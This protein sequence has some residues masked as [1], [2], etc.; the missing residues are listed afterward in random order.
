VNDGIG[1]YTYDLRN[2]LLEQSA[3][4]AGSPPEVRYRYD[5][6]GYRVLA[7]SL[8]AGGGS[9][10][11]LLDPEGVQLV[12]RIYGQSGQQAGEAAFVYL[13][14]RLV[15]KLEG[16]VVKHVIS[17]Q[18]GFPVLVADTPG[19]ILWQV[20]ADAFGEPV[21]VL[22][23]T[24]SEDPLQR[25]PGQWDLGYTDVPVTRGL[26]F[27]GYRWYDSGTGRYTQGDP[28]GF[29]GGFN[30]FSYA[31]QNPFR[32]FDFAGLRPCCSEEIEDALD[33]FIDAYNL[34]FID[35]SLGLDQEDGA[36]Y[37]GPIGNAIYVGT[38]G[39]RGSS[40]TAWAVG[41]LVELQP[42]NTKCCRVV[43][44]QKWLPIP[45]TKVGIECRKETEQS[46]WEIQ[47]RFDPFWRFHKTPY[48]LPYDPVPHF[49]DVPLQWN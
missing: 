22:A 21:F 31:S 28:L 3:A 49:V 36:D 47:M 43:E 6:R 35:P 15:A 8:V 17:N 44:I 1:A 27:N 45:H 13:G 40:C 7:R 24:Q 18:I 48:M 32:L 30:L 9:V 16:S 11:S 10:D 39:N 4:A 37:W 34:W 14:V 5:A 12:N 42:L 25:Y 29:G 26:I 46:D 23:G 2:K 38:L 19:A 20:Q 41:L 33:R